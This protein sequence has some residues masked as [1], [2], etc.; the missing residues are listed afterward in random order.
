MRS[1]ME[2]I[3]EAAANSPHGVRKS[4]CKAKRPSMNVR[5]EPVGFELSTKF[6]SAYSFQPPRNVNSAVAARAG[7]ASVPLTPKNACRRAPPSINA[8]RSTSTGSDPKYHFMLHPK[9]NHQ[10]PP[11]I[12]TT[13]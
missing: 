6:A 9:H 13:P 11:Q 3:T 1:G 7:A 4:P 2:M 10:P 12:T 8:A 5:L